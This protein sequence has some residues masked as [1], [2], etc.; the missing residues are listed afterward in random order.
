MPI[1]CSDITADILGFNENKEDEGKKCKYS[2]TRVQVPEGI[3]LYNA[4]HILGSTQLV[5]ISE[6][7]GKTVYTG[8]FKLRDGLTVKGAKVLECD[9][10]M[11]EC[12][13]GDPSMQFPS[14][15]EI[16]SDMERWARQNRQAIQLW[17]GYSVGKAQEIVKFINEY[18]GETP[19]VGG[20]AAQV[21]KAYER[22]GVKL[23]WV[24]PDSQEGQEMMRGP[25]IAVM[26]PNHI[27]PILAARLAE[28]H[29]RKV[30]TSIATGWALIRKIPADA[31]FPLSDHADFAEILQYAQ[32]SGAKRVIL[33]HGENEKT[34]KALQAAGINAQSI[35]SI[36]EQQMVLAGD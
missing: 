33:M 32:E 8:D 18:L 36:G 29:R 4:G 16:L 35:E 30:L 7:F 34:A 1:F 25:F 23:R 22:N 26:P 2:C 10:L 12:T 24:A 9:T 27:S 6:R 19:I 20:K 5:G 14:Q 3:G 21:C 13:Y 28:V 11:M 17:G 31:S 15:Q